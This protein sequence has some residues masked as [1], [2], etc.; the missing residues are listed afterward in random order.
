[1]S[2]FGVSDYCT[3]EVADHTLALLL[4]LTRGVVAADRAVRAGGWPPALAFGAVRAL[5]D[6]RVGLVGLGRVGAA[7]AARCRAFGASVCAYDPHVPAGEFAAAGVEQV[8]LDD[9]FRCDVVS[10]HVP[11]TAETD[12]L[13]DARR[14]ALLPEHAVLLN[15]S[16]G[17]LVDEEALL[18]ALDAGG[19]AAVGLDVVAAAPPTADSPLR[20][21]PRIAL[22]P[23]IAFYSPQSLQR[24]RRSAAERLVEALG[25][26]VAAA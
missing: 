7:V 1:V 20:S 16:R 12:G 25:A 19:I 8:E 11:L 23:H 24:L 13:V 3:D 26:R 17:G 4:S 9:V 14:L 6:L 10:L 21:H 15:V 5:R 22:T 2:V 18:A